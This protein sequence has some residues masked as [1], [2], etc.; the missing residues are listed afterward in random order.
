MTLS[1]MHAKP[2]TPAR[3]LVLGATGFLG[4]RLLE[5]CARAGIPA[6]GLSSRDLDLT[7]GAAAAGLSERLRPHDVVVFLAA[8]TPDKGRDSGTM[9][10]NLAMGRAVCEATR[11]IEIAQLVYT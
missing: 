8:L 7:D 11:R 4:Q 1:H 6:V 3:V 10:R 2:Q 9:M 5:S